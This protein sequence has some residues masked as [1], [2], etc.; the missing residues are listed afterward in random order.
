VPL[1]A[2][3]AG[4]ESVAREVAV[5]AVPYGAAPVSPGKGQW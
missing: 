5:I 1:S 4:V 3:T 2:N